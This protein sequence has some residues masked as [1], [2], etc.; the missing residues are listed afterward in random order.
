MYDYKHLLLLRDTLD[1][2]SWNAILQLAV[3]YPTADVP[4]VSYKGGRGREGERYR[5]RRE[6]EKDEKEVG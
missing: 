5:G 4:L 6:R 2:S 1:E 3:K